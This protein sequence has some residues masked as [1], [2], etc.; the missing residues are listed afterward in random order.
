MEYQFEDDVIIG[1][2]EGYLKYTAYEDRDGTI[3]QIDI[4]WNGVDML[5]L[6]VELYTE[7]W[8]Y[9]CSTIS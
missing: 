7:I 6:P 4:V 1:D 2:K 3:Q 9:I 5:D 8:N